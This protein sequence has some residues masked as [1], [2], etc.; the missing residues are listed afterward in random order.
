[1]AILCLEDA[2][3]E[4]VKKC[5]YKFDFDPYLTYDYARAKNYGKK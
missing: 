2:F 5:I 3:M 1:M 4:I